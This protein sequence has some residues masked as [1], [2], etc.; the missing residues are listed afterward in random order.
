MGATENEARAAGKTGYWAQYPI[1]MVMTTRTVLF[2]LI[3]LPLVM[4]YFGFTYVYYGV[5]RLASIENLVMM[6]IPFLL[7]VIMLGMVLGQL[8]PRCE[9]VTLV[10]LLSSLPLV[11]SAGFIWP[12]SAIPAVINNLAQLAPSTAAIN[13]FLGLNQLGAT[14]SQE[15]DRW[16]QLWLQFIGF[17]VISYWL[18]R[19][20][21]QMIK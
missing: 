11:F 18:I 13:G 5:N 6:T 12:P 8:L 3:Y 9:L 21:R 10:V 16:G 14:F 4:Y 7:A 15:I 17:M 1:W 2:T 19:R 20:S